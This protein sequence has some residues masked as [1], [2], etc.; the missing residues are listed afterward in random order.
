VKNQAVADYWLGRYEEY[1]RLLSVG[2]FGR[3]ESETYL[4]AAGVGDGYREVAQMHC[5]HKTT[6]DT[7]GVGDMCLVC[8]K[9]LEEGE[10]GD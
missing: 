9:E 10:R 5:R 8:G 6:R 2:H 7:A 4:Y 3:S 1:Q